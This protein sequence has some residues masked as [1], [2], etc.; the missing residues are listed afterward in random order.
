MKEGSQKKERERGR[1]RRRKDGRERERKGGRKRETCI[2]GV[3]EEEG[4]M[5]EQR[6]GKKGRGGR[7]AGE[8][9]G[10]EGG[11]HCTPAKAMP[12]HSLQ[13]HFRG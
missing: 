13:A 1:D 10:Q 3:E 6:E 9:G 12:Q 7:E 2:V 8:E 11:A 5:E 4:G